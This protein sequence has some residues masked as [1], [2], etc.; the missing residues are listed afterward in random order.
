[1]ESELKQTTLE[2]E[3]QSKE[4]EKQSNAWYKLSEKAKEAGEKLQNIG[5]KVKNVGEGL[6]KGITAPILAVGAASIAAFSEVD[7]GLDTIIIKTGITGKGFVELEKSLLSLNKVL[8]MFSVQCLHQPSRLSTAIGVINTRFR[9]TGTELENLSKIF[10]QFAEIHQTDLS[11]SIA[12]TQKIMSQW[13]LDISKTSGLLGFLT[14]EAQFSGISIDK[15]MDSIQRN[16]SV[17]K[18]MGFTLS[19]S[20]AILGEFEKTVL[21]QKL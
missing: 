10:I 1:M 17:L 8:K 21:M 7:E 15:L 18:Q 2:I 5:D 20:I 14:N 6:S 3:K 16:G 19:D 12:K 11:E 4:I 9:V 13:G